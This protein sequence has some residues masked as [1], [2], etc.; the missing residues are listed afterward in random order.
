MTLASLP[1]LVKA[2]LSWLLP[3]QPVQAVARLAPRLACAAIVALSLSRIAALL[4]NYGA[5]MRLYR[6]LPQVRAACPG[7]LHCLAERDPGGAVEGSSRSDGRHAVR[8]AGH[9]FCSGAPCLTLDAQNGGRM[10]TTP[11]AVGCCLQEP[12]LAPGTNVSYVCLGDEW[13]RFPSSFHLPSPAYRLAFVKSGFRGLLP[14]PF[15]L[16]QVIRYTGPFPT[17]GTVLSTSVRCT[18]HELAPVAVDRCWK[19]MRCTDGEARTCCAGGHRCC[20]CTAEQQEQ[21]GAA[22]LLAECRPVPVFCRPAA[23]T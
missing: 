18:F 21:G 6:H 10:R 11:R 9:N 8:H 19:E 14:R 1:A 12:P 15:D 16:Q 5:P 3:R 17:Q 4:N 20:A 2:C 23:L 22:E 7:T 13:H